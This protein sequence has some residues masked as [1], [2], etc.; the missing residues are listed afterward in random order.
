LKHTENAKKI[1]LRDAGFLEADGNMKHR[2][3]RP[4]RVE[5]LTLNDVK[6]FGEK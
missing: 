2:S 5:L 6:F 4:K 1:H 3:F